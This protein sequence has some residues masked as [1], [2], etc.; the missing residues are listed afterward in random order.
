MPSADAILTSTDQKKSGFAETCYVCGAF[1]LFSSTEGNLREAQCALCGT[2]KR[3]SDVARTISSV[4]GE[5]EEEPQPLGAIRSS[6][7]GLR[8]FE[9]QASGPLHDILSQLPGYVCAELLDGVPPGTTS[10]GVRCED[11][12]KLTFGDGTFDLVITQ[13]VLEHVPGFEAAFREIA[14]VLKPGGKHVFTVPYHPGCPTTPRVALDGLGNP[15]E[16][17]PPVYHGD[18][19]RSGGALVA[20]DYG[21]DLP[22]RLRPYGFSTSRFEGGEWYD[23][24]EVTWIYTPEVYAQYLHEVQE[25]GML[26]YFRYNS[27]VFVSHKLALPFTGERFVPELKGQIAHEHLH[28]YAVASEFTRG[29]DVLDIASGEGYGA[30]LLADGASLVVGVDISGES[31]RHAQEKYGNRPNLRFF[32]GS[33]TEIP[34][35]EDAFDVVVSF[36][37][38][39]HI[40]DQEAFLREVRRVLRQDGVFIVSSPNAQEYKRGSEEKNPFHCS[41]L[42]VGEFSDLLSRHFASVDLYGQKVS[43]CSHVWPLQEGDTVVFK[44]FTKWP[45]EVVRTGAVP[46]APE[47]AIAVCSGTTTADPRNASVFHDLTDDMSN[48]FH[49]RGIW[50]Q[51]LEKELQ[52]SRAELQRLREGKSGDAGSSTPSPRR[53]QAEELSRVGRFAESIALLE[54]VITANPNDS[55]ALL[56]LTS[57]CLRAR[58]YSTATILLDRVLERDPVNRRAMELYRSLSIR[59]LTATNASLDLEFAQFPSLGAFEEDRVR[60]SESIAERER[61]VLQMPHDGEEFSVPGH[62]YVCDEDVNFVARVSYVL[63]TPVV[64]WRESLVCPSCGLNNRMRAALHV[65]EQAKRPERGESIY[66]AEQTTPLFAALTARYP[67]TVGSEYL[68]DGFRPGTVSPNGIRHEDL[69]RLSFPSESFETVLSFDVVEHVPDYRKALAECFRVTRP[70]GTLLISVPFE[71]TSPKTIVRALVR[72]DGSVEHL[73]PPEYHG[74]PVNPEQGCLCYQVYGWDLLDT[75]REVGYDHAVAL[76][77]WSDQ[78]GYL[79]GEQ[80]LFMASKPGAA[81]KSSTAGTRT[82]SM[83]PIPMWERDPAFDAVMQ[84]VPYTLVDRQRCFMLYQYALQSIRLGGHVAEVGVYKGGTAKL[85]ATVLE[86]S[87]KMLHLFDTF[88][89]M[90]ETD[91]VKDMHHRG[92]FADTSLA[93]VQQLI[94]RNELVRFYPGFFPATAGPIEGLRFALV[95][96]D[97]D[98][99]RSVLDCSEF[100]YERMTGGGM[101]VYDDYGF[102]SCPGAKQAVDEFFADKPERP[103]YL[104]TGQCVI[105]KL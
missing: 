53:R 4:F 9:A 29:K 86:G 101:M 57:I 98:I 34:A 92:D 52:A 43:T 74:D 60:R 84:Q 11:L 5:N 8:I 54:K 7:A 15:V 10:H 83:S 102:E 79:G 81:P 50:G 24:D 89:G 69:T 14:R 55:E 59:E 72:D 39:E 27:S 16:L 71:R 18:P 66:I 80:L 12:T 85:L 61:E 20:V 40:E 100:F 23:H 91:A 42:T 26:R 3:V 32:R 2:T 31:I 63:G 17:L 13:D 36:E 82:I 68:G 44:A 65:W 33:C 37:T 21:Y 88:E 97:V 75:L 77:Y 58:D 48:A 95:H 78:F 38:I 51:S 46:V 62:C 1:S 96:I 28:R 90:P 94:G 67:N 104:P 6:L 99:Y 41:E 35:P 56:D 22:D 45:D 47:Y 76:S 70:G 64:N 93:S 73:L 87:Q 103:W 25:K 30:R 19:L 105:T 49:E